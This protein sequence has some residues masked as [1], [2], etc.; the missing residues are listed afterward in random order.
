MAG[1]EIY[2]KLENLQK[3]GAF[4]IRGAFNKV[5]SLSPLDRSRGIVT[6]SAGNHAQGVACAGHFYSI[7]AT[8]FMPESAPVAKI[9]ATEGYGAQV[10]LSGKNYDEAYEAAL[11]FGQSSGAAFV[12]AF[13]D[14]EIIAGQGTIGIEILQQLPEAEVL[15]IP[16]GG[17]GLI[18]GVALAAKSIN[19]KIRIIG[20]Q[21]EQANSGFLSWKQGT[22]VHIDNPSSLADGLSVKTP[23]VLPLEMMRRLVDDM[24][25]VSEEEIKGAI[26]LLL[27][28]AKLLVEGAGAVA[29]AAALNRS[30]SLNGKKTVL[31]VSGGNIDLTCLSFLSASGHLAG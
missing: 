23:G 8:V 5:A 6:A 25:T 26:Q 31:L 15:L 4:K 17:G 19:P 22:R 12:H 7:P 11:T 2:L 30:L 1:A 21:P 16:V 13:D 29:L 18:S 14:E 28:R 24:C 10:V 27:E 20:V 9:H 3:T